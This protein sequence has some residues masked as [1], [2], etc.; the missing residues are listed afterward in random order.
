MDIKEFSKEIIKQCLG[1]VDCDTY[2]V[3]KRHLG[4]EFIINAKRDLGYDLEDEE[5]DY[6]VEVMNKQP[7]EVT[8]EEVA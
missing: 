5:I 2:E 6:L 3:M 8:I 1:S 7:K 4:M